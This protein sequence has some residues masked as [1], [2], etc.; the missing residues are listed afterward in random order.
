M[1]ARRGF[2]LFLLVWLLNSCSGYLENRYHDLGDI[3]TLSTQQGYGVGVQA[4]VAMTALGGLQDWQGLSHG[5]WVENEWRPT[6]IYSPYSVPKKTRN[7][8]FQGTSRKGFLYF[9]IN[10]RTA[11]ERKGRGS[12]WNGLV[13][14]P[15]VMGGA[16]T[17]HDLTQV[18]ASFAIGA[19]LRCGVNPLEALDFLLGFGCIDLFSDDIKRQKMESPP[20]DGNPEETPPPARSGGEGAV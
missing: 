12:V 13:I 2:L 9:S 4:S 16:Y 15:T 1:S 8:D 18:E 14:I 7:D 19:G 11:T 5:E 10:E 17:L 20:K 3:V 6:R